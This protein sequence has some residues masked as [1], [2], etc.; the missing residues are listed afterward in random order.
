MPGSKSQHFIPAKM[1][2][3]IEKYEAKL[4]IAYINV[5]TYFLLI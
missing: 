2:V 1:C 5:D 3:N 4:P